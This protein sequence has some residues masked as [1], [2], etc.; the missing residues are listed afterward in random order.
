MANE[1]MLKKL[2]GDFEMKRRY[3]PFYSEDYHPFG[4]MI[5]EP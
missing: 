2:C 4:A 3:N 5:R 1:N